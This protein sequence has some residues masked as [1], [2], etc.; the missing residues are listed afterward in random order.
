MSH[1]TPYSL[2]VPIVSNVSRP[3]S[4]HTDTALQGIGYGSSSKVGMAEHRS[5]GKI[6]I[7]L[8]N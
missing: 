4:E 7:I 1:A 5:Q 6:A 2:E 8:E 3:E